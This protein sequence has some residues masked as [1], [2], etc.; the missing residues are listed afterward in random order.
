MASEAAQ[1]ARSGW[2][3][4]LAHITV[5]SLATKFDA[6][7]H[8]YA[9]RAGCVYSSVTQVLGSV[10][11]NDWMEF[12]P[13]AVLDRARD[14][15]QAVH[16]ACHF[17]DEGDLDWDTLDSEVRPY[18]EHYQEWRAFSRFQPIALETPIINCGF[19]GT[20]DKIG[21]IG[22]DLTIIDLKTGEKAPEAVGVQLFAYSE[23]IGHQFGCRLLSLQLRKERN[24]LL[25]EFTF[26]E[27]VATLAPIWRAALTIEKGR[28]RLKRG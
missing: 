1:S 13:A 19:A 9:D 8:R 24:P 7:E 11:F 3:A 25:T 14:R 2:S 28:P 22:G 21:Y 5:L 26:P 15:G 16:A 10:G 6:A 18:V 12:I 27:Q 23:L 17:L 20:P 4:A